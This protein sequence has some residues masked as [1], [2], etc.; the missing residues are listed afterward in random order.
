MVAA[1][2]MVPVHLIGE[3]ARPLS[4]SVRLFG[5]IMGKD[6]VIAMLLVLVLPVLGKVPPML[7][8][9]RRTPHLQS[10]KLR[11]YGLR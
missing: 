1:P 7:G 4:L 9:C 6:L 8:G 10:S 3:L 5:N 11:E 2:L